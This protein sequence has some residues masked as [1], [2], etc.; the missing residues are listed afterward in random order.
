[1]LKLLYAGMTRVR[2]HSSS[3][4]KFP[5]AATVQVYENMHMAFPGTPWVYIFRRP[6]EVLA[7]MFRV[8]GQNP[9]LRGKKAGSKRPPNAPCTRTKGPGAPAPVKTLL[10]EGS[11]H[12]PQE[13]SHDEYCAAFLAMLCDS[14]ITWHKQALEAPKE[15]HPP[16]MFLNYVSIPQVILA[17]SRQHFGIPLTEEQARK[18]AEEGG[19][20]SKSRAKPGKGGQAFKGDAEDKMA[21]SPDSYHLWSSVYLYER[22][23]AMTALAQGV[24]LLDT[25]QQE[26]LKAEVEWVTSA[27]ETWSA[28]LAKGGSVGQG[29]GQ[30]GPVGL[31]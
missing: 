31:A 6:E 11:G 4:L 8:A 9:R 30:E 17:V 22:Y 5:I 16:G 20:Y 12:S 13:S 26:Q 23:A 10:R 3:V 24:E 14:A 15:E 18:V 25:A 21:Q 28:K 19:V 29:G 27:R 1:M 7:S 2:G